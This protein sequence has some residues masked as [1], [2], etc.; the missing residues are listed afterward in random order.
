M[1][2]NVLLTAIVCYGVLVATLYVLQRS[3]LYPG[4]TGGPPPLS[5]WGEAATIATGDGERLFALYARAAPGRPTV[6]F[7]LGNA[8]RVDRYGFLAA[9]LGERGIGLL[10]LS[11]RGFPGST[12]APS[13]SG[14]L[15]DGIA[16]Y[17]WLA[18]RTDGA[19]ALLGQSLGSGVGVHVAAE[20]PATALVLVSAYDSVL[21]V[22]RRIYFFVPVAPLI[23]DSFRSDL[24]IAGVAQPKLF[25]HGRR[26]T[27]IA[28]AHGEALFAA[29]PGPKRMV[30]LDAYGH[31]DIWTDE[32][33]AE[34]AG[35]VEG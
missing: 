3:L 14:L 18:A 7:F 29:A 16:A 11:Y 35:F 17:D 2:L 10:A 1:L 25:V 6:L 15:A 33:I 9:A 26:D 28:L 8:D 23:R 27:V 13:E 32:R 4:A 5:N 34:I 21:S 30:V 24:R 22:A 12:G 19:I 20:R 31:N